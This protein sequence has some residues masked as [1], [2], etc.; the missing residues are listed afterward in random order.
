MLVGLATGAGVRYRGGMQWLAD[1]GIS[2]TRVALVAGLVAT[3][4]SDDGADAASSAGTVAASS[5]GADDGGDGSGSASMSDTMASASMSGGSTSGGVDTT[6]GE[7]ADSTSTGSGPPTGSEGSEGSDTAGSTG[8]GSGSDSGSGSGSDSGSSDG[9]S[10]GGQEFCDCA[11]NT[12]L[13]YVLSDD[14]ELWSYDPVTNVF[15]FVDAL[16]C[17]LL[18]Q[19]FS[20]GVDRNG[21]AWVMFQDQDIFTVD[22]NN[23]AVCMDPGY[24]PG[25]LGFE[26]FGMAF[27]SESATNPCDQLYAQSYSGGIG[28]QEGPDIGRLGTL[29]PDTLAMSEIGF[30]DYDGGELTGTGDGH[31]YLFAGVNPA[32]II[33]LDKSDASVI[34]I[35]PLDSVELTNAFAFASFAGDF[36]LFTEGANPALSQVT[37][38][39]Y[40]DSDNNGMQD[41]SVIVPQAPIRIVGAGV[42]TCA[43]LPT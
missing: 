7:S 2:V 19:T 28:F 4:C 8:D 40:D 9:G 17:N 26:L 18:G 30:D 25:Q 36:Y 34:S 20:M 38:L 27:V 11:A 14:A 13:I 42:S 22:V 5:G 43:P 10:T 6:I 3:G 16:A 21:I 37:L 33:E 24:N 41:L 1:V 35:L 29:D 31:L 12:D 32:K 23:P 15:A 39:D